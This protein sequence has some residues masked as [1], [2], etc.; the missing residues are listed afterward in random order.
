[1]K[2]IFTLLLVSLLFVGF[3][4]KDNNPSDLLNTKAAALNSIMLN[5][6][7][8][9]ASYYKGN[10][11]LLNFMYFACKPCL[12]EIPTLNNIYTDINSDHFQMLSIAAHTQEQVNAFLSDSGSNYSDVRKRYKIDE[13]KF[14][15][16]A[17]CESKKANT[18]EEEIEL[19]CN[20]ISETFHVR[21]YPATFLIDKNGVVR[22]VFEGFSLT[23]KDSLIEENIK[24]EILKL[25]EE[26]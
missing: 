14:N 2:T 25:L 17:E 21:G 11:T 9:D 3:V 13:I 1:M 22:N 5:G 24:T 23:G 18:N 8:L 15:I 19:M 4:V 6:V 20:T 16:V 12:V 26:K 7:Q 10:V